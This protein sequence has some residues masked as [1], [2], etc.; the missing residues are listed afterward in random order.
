MKDT[1]EKIKESIKEEEEKDMTPILLEDLGMMYTTEKSK[2]RRRYGIFK[3]QYCGKEFKTNFRSV[4]RG[5]T[6]SCGCIV[7][8]HK[9]THGLTTHR[10]YGTWSNMKKRCYN[11]KHQAYPTYGGR[12]ITVCDEW[13]IIE[14]FIK[15]A[16]ETH[17]KGLS[18]DRIDNNK[19]YSPD[20]CRWA[21]KTL[22]V[23]NRRKFKNNKS[24]YIGV[25]FNK[26]TNKWV[27]GIRYKGAYVYIGGYDVP[28]E[29]AL[30]RD[31]YIKENNLPHKL[32]FPNDITKEDSNDER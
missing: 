17:I 12:G 1:K 26:I 32:A 16:E 22:Q 14:N 19:G 8:K 29:G 10:F 31:K 21:D 4:K 11:P 7:N 30:A 28:L 18:L 15:W 20:N 6:R 27:A 9:I 25:S 13:L 2:V 24:G 5:S 3:C 23:L